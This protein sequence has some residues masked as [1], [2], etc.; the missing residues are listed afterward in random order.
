ETPPTTIAPQQITF[1]GEIKKHPLIPDIVTGLT[2]ENIS[3]KGSYASQG[4]DS[5]LNLTATIPRLQ[6]KENTVSDAK[7]LV[8]SANDIIAADLNFNKLQ[9]GTNTLFATSIHANA[10]KDSIGVDAAT[11]DSKGKDRFAIGAVATSK[12]EVY[13]FSMKKNLLLNYQKWEVAGNNKITYGANGVLAENFVLRNGVQQISAISKTNT[14]N[15]PV[16]VSIDSF[17]I[18]DITSLFNSDTLFAAGIVNGKFTISGFDKKIPAFTGNMQ[19]SQ[20]FIM[21]QPVGTIKLFAEK[22]NDNTINATV[23]L[24]ENGNAMNIKGNYYL[25]NE[26]QQFDAAID[27]KRLNMATVQAFSRGNLERASGSITGNVNINGKF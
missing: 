14:L 4:G 27:I 25:N 9:I 23:D 12:N 5:T 24:S 19:L 2:Y 17:D 26:T 1:E 21:Q 18:K 8:S 15:S 22:Q 7:L 16:D 13:T 6:Y 3:F 11:K 20:F 10:A